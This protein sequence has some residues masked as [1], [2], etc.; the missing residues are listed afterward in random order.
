[1]DESLISAAGVKRPDAAPI[2]HFARGVNVKIY[3]L[4][5]V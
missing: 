5:R 2:V 4:E 3:R 1:L